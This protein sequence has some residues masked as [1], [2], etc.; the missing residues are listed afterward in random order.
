MPKKKEYKPSIPFWGHET[1]DGRKF[2]TSPILNAEFWDV[3]QSFEQ[4]GQL[5]LNVVESD[6]ANAP[7]FRLS[8]RPEVEVA[9]WASK[10]PKSKPKAKETEEEGEDEE[11]SAF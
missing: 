6:A 4:N 3:V 11:E 7:A 9:K 2:Y 5:A 10:N 8:G 1:K